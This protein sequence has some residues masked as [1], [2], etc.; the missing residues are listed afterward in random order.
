MGLTRHGLAEIIGR[1]LEDAGVR[2]PGLRVHALRHTFATLALTSRAYTVRELQEALGHASLGT[3][4][5]YLKVTDDDLT[6]AAS[7]HPLAH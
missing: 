4:G 7:A 5:R 6:R 3:T 2:R 1:C